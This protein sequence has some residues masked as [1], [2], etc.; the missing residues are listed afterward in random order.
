ME[1]VRLI[2][3]GILKK[4]DEKPLNNIIINTGFYIIN[5]SLFKYIPKGRFFHITDLISKAQSKKK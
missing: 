4:V 1:F 3:K 2:K 5:K